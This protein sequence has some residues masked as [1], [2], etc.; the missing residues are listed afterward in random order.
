VANGSAL[1][2]DSQNPQEIAEVVQKLLSDKT[3]KDGIIEKGLEN[4]RRFSWDSCAQKISN[5]LTT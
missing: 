4:V 2:V 5:I 1:L 3:F